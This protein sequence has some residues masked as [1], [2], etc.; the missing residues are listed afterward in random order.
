[1][2]I[3]R[4][5]MGFRE[6]ADRHRECPKTP[7]SPYQPGRFQMGRGC[8]TPGICRFPDHG[9]PFYASRQCWFIRV[10]SKNWCIQ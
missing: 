9:Y 6:S 5:K 8:G 3:L 7:E 10:N 2:D 4:K 1:M